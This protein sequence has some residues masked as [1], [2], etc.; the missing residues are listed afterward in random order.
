MRIRILICE[1][2]HQYAKNLKN[3][4]NNDFAYLHTLII[5][6]YFNIVFKQLVNSSVACQL[7]YRH[8]VQTSMPQ[9]IYYNGICMLA[10]ILYFV[11][12]TTINTG[13]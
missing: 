10:T 11:I 8:V 13:L 3:M 7:T 6:F 12:A 5:A 9:S 2:E 1:N 4:R